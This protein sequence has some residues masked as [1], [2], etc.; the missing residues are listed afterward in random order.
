MTILAILR[1]LAFGMLL[2]LLS[3]LVVRA[4][5]ALRVMD[6]PEARKAH[7]RP[8]PKG[9]GAGIV[10]AFLAGLLLLYAFAQFARLANEY[11]LGVIA[12]S[13]AIALV[14]FLDD[15]FDWPFAVKLGIQAV[16]A[17]VAVSTGIYLHDYRIPNVGPVHV[18]W[19][20]PPV[21]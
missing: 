16:A 5:I 17:L 20:G 19:I 2:A 8:T 13:V 10:V 6:T 3:A 21:T 18:G 4:M 7:D 12:A 1:H 9:G 11:F 14:A 15:L